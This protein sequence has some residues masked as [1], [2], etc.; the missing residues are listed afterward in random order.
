MEPLRISGNRFARMHDV[1]N[2]Q[3][4]VDLPGQMVVRQIDQKRVNVGPTEQHDYRPQ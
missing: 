3:H 1:T 4:L 2:E